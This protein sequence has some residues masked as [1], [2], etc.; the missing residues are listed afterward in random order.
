MWC[1]VMWV[2]EVGG[3]G[4][5]WGCGACQADTGGSGLCHASSVRGQQARPASVVR[6]HGGATWW[7]NACVCFVSSVCSPHTTAPTSPRDR[8]PSSS[9][10]TGREAGSRGGALEDENASFLAAWVLPPMAASQADVPP[11][12]WQYWP[13]LLLSG[14]DLSQAHR[15]TGRQHRHAARPRAAETLHPVVLHPVVPRLRAAR[16]SVG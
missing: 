5:V 3:V 10:R 7:T 11:S 1:G 2:Q 16:R 4:R 14:V 12:V 15:L 13:R 8:I 9:R 6:S